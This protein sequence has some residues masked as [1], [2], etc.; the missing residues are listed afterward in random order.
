MTAIKICGLS[1][2][3]HALAAATAGAD[4]IGLVFA[5]SRRRVEGDQ[6]MTVITALRQHPAGKG[7]GVVGLFVN[8]Q[9]AH[10]NRISD[11]CGLDYVQL[12]GD[13]TVQQ[14]AG[15]NRP[16]IKSVRLDG[17]PLETAWLQVAAQAQPDQPGNAANH[18][19]QG[20]RLAPCPLIIDAHVPGSY[21]GT[22][23]LADWERAAN[24][25]Q[26]QPVMLAGGL[27][28]ANVAAAITR[29]QPWGVD[30]SSGVERDGKK[31][32]ELIEAFIC[33]VRSTAY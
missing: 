15:I 5:N 22:G 8:E 28:P 11:Q 4:F 3:E 10:I 33:A 2:R 23:T 1:T 30:V 7:V 32:S 12:S 20:V 17:S 24:L 13:E 25:A 14:A 16:V 27:Q 31:D 19:D 29:V 18:R 9:A 6:A 26:Q 21:G